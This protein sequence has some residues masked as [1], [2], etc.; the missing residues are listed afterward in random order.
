M[1]RNEEDRIKFVELAE[2]RVNRARNYIRLVGN[3][4][5]RSN[6]DYTEEDAKKIYTA[7][8]KSLQ[9]MKARFDSKGAEGGDEFKL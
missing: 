6:Y 4:S 5:N 7:L 8:Y 3:L 1:A 9:E 2:Y